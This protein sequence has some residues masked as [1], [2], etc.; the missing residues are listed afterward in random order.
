MNLNSI[1]LVI[2]AIRMKETIGTGI[3][4]VFQINIILNTTIKTRKLIIGLILTQT[5]LNFINLI[6]YTKTLKI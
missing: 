3:K 4:M 5:D 1:N 2:K 6:I